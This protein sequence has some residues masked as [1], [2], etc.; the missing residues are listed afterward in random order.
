VRGQEDSVKPCF[1]GFD[2]SKWG[3]IHK[4]NIGRGSM[5]RDFAIHQCHYKKEKFPDACGG[6]DRMNQIGTPDGD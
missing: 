6:Y 5:K 4:S 2:S 1:K 3:L